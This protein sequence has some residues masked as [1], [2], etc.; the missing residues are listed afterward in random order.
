MFRVVGKFQR[1]ALARQLHGSAPRAS[2]FKN[3]KDQIEKGI[4]EEGVDKDIKKVKVDMTKLSQDIE[5]SAEK[6]GESE[7]FKKIMKWV[8]RFQKLCD[9]MVFG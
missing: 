3:L 6:F 5:K 7:K 1:Q 9:P 4:K 2:F 8:L